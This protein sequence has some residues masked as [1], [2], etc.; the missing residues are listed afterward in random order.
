[1]SGVV[2]SPSLL[3]PKKIKIPGGKVPIKAEEPASS[4]PPKLK[5]K[6]STSGPPDPGPPPKKP[7]KAEDI[8]VLER[9]KAVT[10]DDEPVDIGEIN[11]SRLREVM[12]LVAA[13]NKF[14]EGMDRGELMAAAGQMLAEEGKAIRFKK[15]NV[16]LDAK[17]HWKT[18][19]PE[20]RRPYEAKVCA[21]AQRAQRGDARATMWPSPAR[22]LRTHTRALW[23]QRVAMRV[24]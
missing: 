23:P 22:C 11:E 9:F 3:P 24:H 7:K 20:T 16:Q 21:A 12:R 19:Q 13:D 8:Y 10:F 18:M 5:H 1:M 4:G 17:A 2:S 15:S 14:D 6:Q